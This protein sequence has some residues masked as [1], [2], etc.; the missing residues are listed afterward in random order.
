MTFR[1]SLRCWSYRGWDISLRRKTLELRCVLCF[2]SR[3]LWQRHPFGTG[4]VC[5]QAEACDYQNVWI[6]G[7]FG[8]GRFHN[9][10][11]C[12]LRYTLPA[13][14]DSRTKRWTKRTPFGAHLRSVSLVLNCRIFRKTA[15]EAEPNMFYRLAK[16]RCFLAGL[17]S[18]FIK[19]Y[20]SCWVNNFSAVCIKT[21]PAM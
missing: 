1:R 14:Y 21:A 6:I 2:G 17:R 7:F 16:S 4:R 5:A 13:G 11:G 12:D 10:K 19:K 15:A 9:K 18:L 8:S 20:L 3:D